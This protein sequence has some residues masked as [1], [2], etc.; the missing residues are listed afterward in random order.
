MRTSANRSGSCRSV[1]A[2]I[3]A[4]GAASAAL[5]G[6]AQTWPFDI[7]T[8]GGDVF[9]SSTTAV[10]P[11]ADEYVGTY[12][13]T[14]VFATGTAGILT[15]GP[16]DVT[17]QI[18]PK[19]LS[20]NGTAAGP[21]PVTIFSD[22]IIAPSP[23]EPAAVIATIDITLDSAGFGML[24]ATDV[25][26]GPFTASFPP[27]GTVT[28]NLTAIRLVGSVTVDP[29]TTATPGDITGDGVV[30][31]L[32]LGNLLANW[33][34]PPG[35]PGCGG[36]RPCLADINQDGVVDGIDLGILLANWTL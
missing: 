30:D 18:P 26:L 33:S 12:N 8:T 21:A 17:S 13:V 29:N 19:F 7:T 24:S 1:A 36:A 4:L 16:V 3:L 28:I 25:T 2:A 11:D 15:I 20:G 23:P 31:G 5:A 10:D 22:T 34:I 27:F 35:A 14:Q 32:D 6:G 9:F